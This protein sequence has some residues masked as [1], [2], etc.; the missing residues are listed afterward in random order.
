VLAQFPIAPLSMDVDMLMAGVMYG[1]TDDL[2]LMAM[3]PY[4][5]KS[6]D[7]VTRGGAAFTTRSEGVGDARAILAYDLYKQGGQSLE[8]AGGLSVPTGSIDE[9]DTTPAGPG[10]V[11]PYPMQIGS[12]TWD[13]IPALTYRGQATR[14][15]WGAQATA[16]IRL[17]ENGEDYT[18]GNIYG[19][20]AWAAWPLNDWLGAS[21]RINGEVVE[22][23]DGADPRLSPAAVPTGEPSL[24]AGQTAM[25]GLGL[26]LVV[27]EGPAAG[28]RVSLEA[29]MPIYQRVDGPQVERDNMVLLRIGT[30]F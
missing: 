23:I 26:N 21:L 4:V 15:S 28:T 17:G 22:D 5:W 2:S 30:A 14:W 13:L 25:V 20:T 29:L 27:P 11:L 6:M 24:R 19:A 10:Q 18:L 8:I 12:G 1:I 3:V 16:T 9:R 7:H